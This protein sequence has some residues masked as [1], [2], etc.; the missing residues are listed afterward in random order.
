[1]ATVNFA[2]KRPAAR[3]RAKARESAPAYGVP[4][5]VLS[6]RHGLRARERGTIDRAL[7]I[8]NRVM[9]QREVF[10]TPDAVKHFLQLRLAGENVRALRCAVPG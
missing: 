8:L 10:T 3:P 5:G 6:F 2:S 7:A 9:C 4:D 1:M